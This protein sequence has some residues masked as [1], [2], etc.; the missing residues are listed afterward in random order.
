VPLPLEDYALIGD[1]QTAG[2]VGRDGSLDWLCLPRFDAPACFAALLGTPAH[3]RWSIAPRG[4]S[5]AVRRRYRPHSLV[6]EQEFETPTGRVRLT[7]FMPPR[8]S[9]PDLVRIVEGL[10]GKVELEMEL[11]IRFDYGSIVPWVRRV[12]DHLLAIAGPDALYLWTPA[13]IEGHDLTTAARFEV[14]AGDSVPFVLAWHPSH[15]SLSNPVPD[16][17]AALEDTCRWWEAWAGRCTYE[18]PWREQ[19]V[20]SLITLKALTYAPTGG[21]VAAPTTSLPEQLGGVRNWDYRYCWLRDATFTLFALMV[22]GYT[23]EAAS[24]R[25]WLLRAVAGDPN[26]LQ[27][28]YGPAGERRLTETEVSWLPG[29]EDAR[30]VRIGN[31]ASG[32]RQLDVFGEVMDVLDAARRAGM[33]PDANAWALQQELL[34][35]LETIW[36]EPDEGIWEVR[37]PR[38]HFT[39][40]KVMAWVAFDRAVRAV[41]EAG[42][43]GPVHRWRSLRSAI[44][45]E[46]CAKG[47]NEA[48][49]AFTQYYGATIPDA[50]LLMIPLVGFLPA[51][52]PRVAGTVA[53]VERELLRNGLVSRYPRETSHVDGLPPGEGAFLPCSF[54]LVDNYVLAGRRD[55]A[56][57]LFE[58]LLALANDVGLLAEEYDPASRRLVGNYPQA[59]SHVALVNTARNLARSHGPAERRREGARPEPRR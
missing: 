53:L 39:H 58:R 24:W 50:S 9:E 25:N 56:T 18:G 43:D 11:R 7:D 23:E 36:Q 1:T 4:A 3:G 34:R 46:V 57:A 30:P 38:R 59:F 52:D 47:F 40:S 6:L 10:A 29:Y 27:I 22:G 16:P 37:G 21:I 14:R 15:L 55:D 31:A 5:R 51:D 35:H 48:L 28:L 49:G 12:D 17:A 33:P 26:D 13:P 20:R 54:W 2:L 44:H 19:V 45:R 8:G 41:E 32:Q 42:A